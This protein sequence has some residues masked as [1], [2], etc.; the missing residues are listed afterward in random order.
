MDGILLEKRQMTGTKRQVE[1]MLAAVVLLITAPVHAQSQNVGRVISAVPLDYDRV[2]GSRSPPYTPGQVT[3]NEVGI[4]EG[5]RGKSGWISVD[6]WGSY[7]DEAANSTVRL[8]IENVSFW[9]NRGGRNW[10]DFEVGK[11]TLEEDTTVAIPFATTIEPLSADENTLVLLV[12]N[13]YRLVPV[14]ADL[15]SISFQQEDF[16]A[17][18]DPGNGHV[19]GAGA[20]AHL[21]T[22]V[23]TPFT[24]KPLLNNREEVAAVY[25]REYPP[26]LEDD[27]IGGTVLLWVFIDENGSTQ[28]CLVARSS[29]HQALD[30]AAL[31][32]AAVMRFSAALNGERKVPVWVSIPLT[33]TARIRR[34]S[35][36]GIRALSV[37]AAVSDEP[38]SP[39]T[40]LDN[41]GW[42][43]VT[44]EMPRRCNLRRGLW[45]LHGPGPI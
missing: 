17:R 32:V 25:R 10:W 30:S 13:K 19:C 23:F 21:A 28:D 15:Q 44:R 38:M 1:G 24:V 42:L 26:Q 22:P 27:G 18:E 39:I 29:G 35:P 4:I 20:P 33:F 7:V 45:F 5:D 36:V 12:E 8:R 11:V 16:A 2:T 6:T 41:D 43:P 3:L 37:Q 40:V 9:V 31:A 34:T 14:V